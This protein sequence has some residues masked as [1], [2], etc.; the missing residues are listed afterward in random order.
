[1]LICTYTLRIVTIT[2][3]SLTM[4]SLL[5]ETITIIN[6]LISKIQVIDFVQR[7]VI[8]LVFNLQENDTAIYVT[9]DAT[10]LLA[11]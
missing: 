1:M 8:F 3:G 9:F 7:R 5:T 4:T 2:Q 11:I 6:E 10:H